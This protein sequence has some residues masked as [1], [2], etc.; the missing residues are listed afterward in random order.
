M[1]PRISKKVLPEII[2]AEWIEQIT[3]VDGE[4]I[5]KLSL[6]DLARRRNPRKLYRAGPALSG[7]AWT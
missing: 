5:I 3:S 7:G 4:V 1:P 6:K 2:D